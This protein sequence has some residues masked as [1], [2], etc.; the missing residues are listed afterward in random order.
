MNS[1]RFLNFLF[2]NTWTHYYLIKQIPNPIFRGSAPPWLKKIVWVTLATQQWSSKYTTKIRAR[3][4]NV[5]TKLTSNKFAIGTCWVLIKYYIVRCDLTKRIIGTNIS[6]LSWRFLYNHFYTMWLGPKDIVQTS[7]KDLT[8][9]GGLLAL[10]TNAR[11]LCLDSL[12]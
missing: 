11:I 2:S 1:D 10:P 5:P 3:L 4:Y 7:F 6:S 8:T 12:L 9:F